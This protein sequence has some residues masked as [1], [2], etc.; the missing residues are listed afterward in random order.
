VSLGL[1]SQKSKSQIT[2]SKFQTNPNIQVSKLIYSK[3]VL[4]GILNF[5]HWNLFGA[6]DFFPAIGNAPKQSYSREAA[7]KPPMG[8]RSKS[9]APNSKQIP[10]SNS[11][12]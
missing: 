8:G 9:Q 5:G 3:A 4:F 2:S 12:N 6:W 1:P 10:I 7:A 11:Q